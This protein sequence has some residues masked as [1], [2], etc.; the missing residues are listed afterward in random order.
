VH[1][2]LEVQGSE[3]LTGLPLQAASPA[4]QVEVRARPSSTLSVRPTM[5]NVGQPFTLTLR[6]TND[7]ESRWLNVWP[8]RPTIEG[9]S[10]VLPPE[11]TPRSVNLEPQES[12]EFVWIGFATTT[13]EGRFKVRAVGTEESTGDEV[14]IAEVTSPLFT[15]VKPGAREVR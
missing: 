11:S 5:V 14:P 2:A 13:G 6:V 1:F 12:R 8:W 3:E 10:V 9:V 4:L 7:S 15:V